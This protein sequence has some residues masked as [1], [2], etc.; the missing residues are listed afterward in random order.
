[1][2]ETIEKMVGLVENLHEENTNLNK[3]TDDRSTYLSIEEALN[4][5]KSNLK[6]K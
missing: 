4:I 1:M 6:G 2:V 5:I 3:L